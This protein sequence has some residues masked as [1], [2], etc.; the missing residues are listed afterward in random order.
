MPDFTTRT[1]Q[2]H[3][4]RIDEVSIDGILGQIGITFCPGKSHKNAISGTWDRDLDTDIDVVRAWGAT[5]WVNLLTWEEMG[6]LGVSDLGMVVG[7]PRVGFRYYLLPIEDGGVP[8]ADFERKWEAAG[9]E[10]REDILRGGKVLIH[11]KGGLGRSGTIAARLLVEL[12]AKPSEAIRRVREARPGAIENALQESHV[13]SIKPKTRSVAEIRR[14]PSDPW[15]RSRFRGCLLGGAAGDALGA[16]V[17][18]MKLDQ[19]RARFGPEGIRSLSP[20]YGRLG[21]I[22][23]DTQMT[24]FTAE[25]FLRGFVRQKSRG[26]ASLEGM[27]AHAYQRWLKTQGVRPSQDF[28]IDSGWLI[29]AKDLHARRA[30]GNTCL[31]ALKETKTLGDP[32]SNDSKGCGGVM[33][34]APIGMGSFLLDG[35]PDAATDFA[36]SHGVGVAALTHGH[37]SGKLPAGALSA[38][39]VL[40][41]NKVPLKDALGRVSS[42]LEKQ[43]GHEETLKAI[44]NAMAL[45]SARPGSVEAIR[46][47]GEGWT[48]EEALAIAI[49]CTLSAEDFESGVILA[50]NHDGDSDSTGAITGNILGALHGV[51]AI[52]QRWL[53]T[54]E[55]RAVIEELADDLAT[56]VEWD[57][58]EYSQDKDEATYYWN[59]YPGM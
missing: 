57:V 34:V 28:D 2:T 29:R 31:S 53:E 5:I 17:E 50:V 55:L 23:D 37:P 19:I 13:R 33:R 3:P 56:F 14:V 44:R 52:P 27:I 35:D 51:E 15:L 18:F 46:E 59:R 20:A 49:Y 22:T 36:F 38:L 10:I 39:I 32:A 24:L 1:S 48:A 45:A 25:G 7:A 54:L 11:C 40:V 41:L 58:G 9:R 43:S 26:L 30:P 4:L 42:I 8:D 12:G 16:P 47:V 6:Q 21:T